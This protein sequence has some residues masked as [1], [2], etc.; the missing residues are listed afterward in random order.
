VSSFGGI[1]IAD[2]RELLEKAEQRRVG[3]AFVQLRRGGGERGNRIGAVAWLVVCLGAAE[4][5]GSKPRL[6]GG[7]LGRRARVRWAHGCLSYPGA[8]VRPDGIEFPRRAQQ[9]QQ[10]L[11]PVFAFLSFQPEPIGVAAL[12]HDELDRVGGAWRGPDRVA[13]P[14]QQLAKRT[15]LGARRWSE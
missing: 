9:L 3:R 5:T 15:Q 7:R 14:A 4:R 2:E 1:G 11:Q 8:R 12:V 10:V 13:E 6:R